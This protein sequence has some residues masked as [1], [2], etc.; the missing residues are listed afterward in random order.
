MQVFSIAKGFNKVSTY[1]RYQL[2]GKELD[3]LR[4]LRVWQE[5]NVSYV[6][7]EYN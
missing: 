5:T 2:S 7:N 4:A 1:D 6:V 3:R